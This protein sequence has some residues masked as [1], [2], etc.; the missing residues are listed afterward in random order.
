MS[1]GFKIHWTEH[2][3]I[4]LNDIL[5]YLRENWSEREIVQFVKALER[6]IDIASRFPEI[7]PVSQQRVNM[8]R[9]V[10][11]KQNTVYYRIVGSSLHILSVYG[12]RRN[13]FSV[14]SQ[15]SIDSE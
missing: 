13:P 14:Q 1:G 8:R 15:G 6:T 7:Y 5:D 11:D 4:E 9:A 2:A 10:V 12:H 3:S